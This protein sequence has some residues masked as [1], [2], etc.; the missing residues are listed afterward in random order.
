MSSAKFQNLRDEARLEL[1]QANREW[2]ECVSNNFLPQW[3]SGAQVNVEEV[4]REQQ[5]RL[6]ELNESIYAEKPNPIRQFNLP[7]TQ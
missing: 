6:T 3:L 4:C 1:K 5:E 2:T 7:T